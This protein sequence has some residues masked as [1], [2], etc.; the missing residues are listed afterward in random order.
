[1]PHAGGDE[2][3]NGRAY[4]AQDVVCPTQVG[5][6]RWMSVALPAYASMPHAGGDEPH[7]ADLGDIAAEYAPRRWG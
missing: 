6:N 3:K 5:M 1:M 7:S 2:P 4:F